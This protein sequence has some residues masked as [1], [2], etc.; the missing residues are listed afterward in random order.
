MPV[1]DEE[2]EVTGAV[3]DKYPEAMGVYPVRV[4]SRAL[5]LK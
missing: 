2:E 1:E 5:P 3:A 4:P